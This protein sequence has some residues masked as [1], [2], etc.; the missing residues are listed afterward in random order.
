MKIKE[1]MLDGEWINAGIGFVVKGE[2]YMQGFIVI[3]GFLVDKG[4]E[5]IELVPLDAFQYPIQ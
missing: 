2:P 5:D 1:S 4:D 3:T